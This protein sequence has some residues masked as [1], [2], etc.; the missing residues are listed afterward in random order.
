ME[1]SES[2]S[3]TF[4][5][6]CDFSK[7]DQAPGFCTR[8]TLYTQ[9][10]REVN[11]R[12]FSRNILSPLGQPSSKT[13][14]TVYSVYS[15]RVK[16]D[17]CHRTGNDSSLEAP[18][19]PLVTPSSPLPPTSPTPQRPL[20]KLEPALVRS[21]NRPQK[22]FWVRGEAHWNRLAPSFRMRY[23]VLQTEFI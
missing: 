7:H 19:F 9:D 18:T 22:F 13:V 15:A 3:G 20:W 1:K 2:P 12:L 14:C 4:C 5:G 21:F 23:S 17:G 11:Q 6:R 10:L 16:G 8:C